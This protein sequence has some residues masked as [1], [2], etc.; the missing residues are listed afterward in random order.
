MAEIQNGKLTLNRYRYLLYPSF[1][2]GSL[3]PWDALCLAAQLVMNCPIDRESDVQS[4]ERAVSESLGLPYV[5]A[6][7]AGRMALYVLLKSLELEKGSE[8]IL[9]GYTCVV[10]PNAVRF[11]GCRPR[12]VD[13][14]LS[15]FNMDPDAFESAITPNTRVV[16]MQHTFGIPADIAR[17]QDICRRHKLFLIEDGAHALGAMYG[18]KPVGFWG[19]AALFSTETSKMISTDKGGLLV[20]SD[21]ALAAKI[22]SLYVSL[23]IR[24]PELERLACKR[25]IYNVLTQDPWLNPIWRTLNRVFGL[26]IA[27]LPTFKAYFS[28]HQ[29]EYEAE[30]AGV[31]FA[32]Y[33]RRL[34]GILCRIGELQVHRLT[35]DVRKRN[36]KAAFLAEIL[37]KFG[38]RVPTYDHA[39]CYPSFVKFPFLVEDRKKWVKAL[40]KLKL[41]NFTWLND[42]LHPRETRCHMENN[43]TWG[44]C[45]N[46]EY[47]SQYILN[48]PVGRSVS[49]SMLSRLKNLNL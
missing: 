8:V 13:I 31:Q 43:Y 28:S 44:S 26:S 40:D 22:R 29:S 23:P 20:T 18:G 12:Y 25:V 48:L 34:A 6:L 16:L 32:S 1:L 45:P 21:S 15:D 24:S 30:L 7:G 3:S 35:E 37:P 2:N 36:E 49:F 39:L 42:P 10:M 9:P 4:Y 14:R 27:D 19:D 11:A 47:A 17:I 38:A 33:P 46:A 5:F 41:P